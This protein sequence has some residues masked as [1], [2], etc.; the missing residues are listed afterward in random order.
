M[1]KN[2]K[3]LL[4]ASLIAVLVFIGIIIMAKD[5]LYKGP[6]V[7]S[8]EKIVINYSKDISI[9]QLVAQQI[10]VV[11]EKGNKIKAEVNFWNGSNRI[12]IINPP[13]DGFK[14]GKKLTLKINTNIN[15]NINGEVSNIKN[16]TFK[17][18]KDR[19]LEFEDSNFTLGVRRQISLP[20][21]DI[22]Y[23]MVYN[24]KGLSMD[25]FNIKS[26]KG[27]KNFGSLTELNLSGNKIN[28][29][30][31]LKNLKQLQVLSLANNDISDIS[32]LKDLKN[33]NT[34]WLNGNKIKD[35]S[36]TTGYYSN[37]KS[38][39]FKLN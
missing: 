15:F 1:F 16:W 17:V 4:G 25:N 36:V 6:F 12:V 2:K 24:L 31:E 21:G 14:R 27:I 9:L 20:K 29:I 7:Y 33:L 38:K 28:K 23:G 30:E 35:Y 37:L 11:D 8:Y 34:L 26:I 3:I 19:V 5:L 13:I 32:S 10:E 22:Y 18:K 39:D